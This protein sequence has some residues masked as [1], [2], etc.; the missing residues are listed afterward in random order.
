MSWRIVSEDKSD[1][2]G[3]KGPIITHDLTYTI[4]KMFSGF[5]EDLQFGSDIAAIF[6][7]K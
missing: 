7:P 2:E 3:R 6:I 1:K 5:T 4:R